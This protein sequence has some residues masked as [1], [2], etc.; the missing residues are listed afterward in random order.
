MDSGQLK[1]KGFSSWFLLDKNSIA[2]VP[3]YPGVYILRRGQG[4]FFGRL[5]GQSD[6]LYIGSTEANQGLKQRLR[7]YIFPGPTQWTNKRINE[8]LSKYRIEV[9]WLRCEEP[10]NL[11]HALLK[12]YVNEHDELPPLNHATRRLL[13]K[14][15]ED[16]IKIS[17]CGK[18]EK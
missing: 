17:D 5:S 13:R 12:W 15:V 8:M 9:A 4:V 6:I 14:V 18:I 3:A 1:E 7:Q 10:G 16:K 2:N 11:E